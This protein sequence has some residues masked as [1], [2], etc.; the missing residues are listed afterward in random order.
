MLK[1]S[2]KIPDFPQ[3]GDEAFFEGLDKV[4][5]ND[6]TEAFKCFEKGSRYENEYASLL[7][8]SFY[9]AGFI[10]S[11]KREPEKSLELYKKV[12]N[13][14]N[15]YLAQYLIGC[16]LIKGDIDGVSPNFKEGIRWL[17]VAAENGWND[18]NIRIGMAYQYGE[19]N[20]TVNYDT[21]MSYYLKVIDSDTYYGYPKNTQLGLFGH[22]DFQITFIDGFKY[23]DE[24]I[25][26]RISHIIT[27]QAASFFRHPNKSINDVLL[28]GVFWYIFTGQGYAIHLLLL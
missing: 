12:A 4:N 25:N 19:G 1:I 10:P 18:A 21:A 24:L 11:G 22:T 26:V 2:Y 14:H 23:F 15:N 17:K 9:Q 28:K 7:V 13:K 8:A 16:M 5:Q 3:P 27:P 6:Y 20:L